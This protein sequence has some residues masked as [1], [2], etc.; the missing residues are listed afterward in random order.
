MIL[1]AMAHAFSLDIQW[2]AELFMDNLLWVFIFYATAN[3]LDKSRTFAGSV[4]LFLFF[5]YDFFTETSF[6]QAAG[7][8]LTGVGFLAILYLTR[9]AFTAVVEYTPKL[10]PHMLKLS[11]LH[12]LVVLVFYN[13]FMS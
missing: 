10:K 8:T 2:F 9:T 13:V 11:A 1:E 7:W 4:W 5:V 12:W 3:L 6:T